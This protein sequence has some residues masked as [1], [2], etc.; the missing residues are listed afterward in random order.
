M[1]QE[2]DK[3]S[4]NL[5]SRLQELRSKRNLTQEA[6]SKLADLPRSTI[7]NLESGNGNPS[8]INLSKISEA[9]SVPIEHLLTPT[10]AVTK[11]V[12]SSDLKKI[13][14]L[15]GELMI[16]KLIPDPIQGMEIDKIEINPKAKM[17]GIPHATGTREYFHCVSGEFL[18]TVEDEIFELSRGDVLTFPGESRH[19]YENSSKCKSTGLSVVVF[20]PAS[21]E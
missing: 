11:L 19:S 18:V 14:R 15:G 12:R 1:G 9:L 7:A 13:T 10:K 8:L 20:V 5:A 3:I 21:Q 17:R 16:T 6:L 4:Q 2:F